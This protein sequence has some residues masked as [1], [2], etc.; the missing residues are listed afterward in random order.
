MRRPVGPHSPF[1]HR[2]LRHLEVIG[3]DAAPRLLGTDAK[4]REILSFQHGEAPT[5]F[6]ARD[7]SPAQITAAAQLLRRL[8]DAIAG[9]PIAGGEETACHNVFSP[10]NVAFVDGLPVS[11][12]DFDQAAPRPRTRDL[13]YAAWLWLLGADIDGHLDCQLALL[14]TFLDTYGLADE[15]RRGFGGCV[16]ARVGD[17][18]DF[19]A[20]A[21]R[22]GGPG[23]WLHRDRLVRGAR[24]RHRPGLGK[25]QPATPT[26]APS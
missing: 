6:R 8:H 3:S 21:G 9:T 4:G 26:T 7:W 19:H 16:V 10:L 18:R 14:R 11:A 22:V 5:A 1:V 23:S 12:F 2:L 17:E 15:G 25:Q 20:R 24:R 13:A